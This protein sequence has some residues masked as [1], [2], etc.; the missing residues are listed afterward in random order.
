MTVVV[1][2]LD[3]ETEVEMV[4]PDV[5]SDVES[6]F[7]VYKF[8]KSYILSILKSIG[9]QVSQTQTVVNITVESFSESAADV[10]S[11]VARV[12]MVEVSVAI[13]FMLLLV[14]N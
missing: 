14:F 9:S 10:A 11:E 2:V 3:S 6:L 7:W 8:H 5:E 4:I 13:C 12:V 1:V